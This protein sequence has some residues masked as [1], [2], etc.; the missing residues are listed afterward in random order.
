M[1]GLKEFYKKKKFRELSLKTNF[2]SRK[3]K[4]EYELFKRHFPAGCI[5]RDDIEE[6]I[7]TVL[8]ENYCHTIR[9]K[10]QQPQ[11]LST[12]LHISNFIFLYSKMIVEEFG[13]SQNSSLDFK[14]Y[15]LGKIR[16][17]IVQ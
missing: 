8:P 9:C 14:Q 16:V 5:E 17:K 4:E 2:S 3:I 12:F 15:I 11:P 7:L 10:W 1:D 13:D 6:A